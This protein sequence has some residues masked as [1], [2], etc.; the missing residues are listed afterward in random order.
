MNWSTIL[1]EKW[2]LQKNEMIISWNFKIYHALQIMNTKIF[3]SALDTPENKTNF[4]YLTMDSQRSIFQTFASQALTLTSYKIIYTYRKI[5]LN[6]FIV[7][8]LFSIH[9]V[10][11]HTI[12]KSK[13]N[14]VIVLEYSNH[15]KIIHAPV[16]LHCCSTLHFHFGIRLPGSL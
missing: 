7:S 5:R 1:T 10:Q 4:M 8:V 13:E 2:F 16:I 14:L 12:Q 15:R 11:E 3:I 9:S 6:Y